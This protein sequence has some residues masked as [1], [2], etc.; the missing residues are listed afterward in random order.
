ML[1]LLPG[2]ARYAVAVAATAIPIALHAAL[3]PLWG[4]DLSLITFYA[5][6][7]V[8]AWL[9][10]MGPALLAT[11]LSAAAAYLWMPATGPPAGLFGKAAS[12]GLFIG[13]GVL[14]SIL[15]GALHRARARLTDNARALQN[16]TATS[17]EDAEALNRLAAIVRS[18]DD[19]I[20][21]KTLEG[22]I[23]TWNEAA[24]RMFGWTAEEAIGKS[25][26]LIIPHDRLREEEMVLSMIRRGEP[27][28]HFRTVRVHK[29]GK[30]L[31][32]SLTVSPVRNAAGEVVGASKI[33]RDV[34]AIAEADD[35]R[36]IL[37]MR[38]QAARTEAETANRTKDEF[39][40]MLG[41]ELRNP[42]SAISNAAQ[43]LERAGKPDDSTA[44]A[45]G[46]IVRQTANLARLMDGLLDV[47]RVMT[48]KILLDRKLVDLGEV[49]ERALAALREAGR[50]ER[51]LV[52]FDGTPVTIDA[53]ATRIEQ[54]VT[55]LVT[56][57]LKYTPQGGAVRIRVTQEGRAAVL[58]V[59]DD[60][61]GIAPALLP[62]VFDLFVQGP[63]PLDRSSG[64]L[65]IG[66][67][68]VKQVT[69]LHGGTVI[70]ASDGPGK[71]TTVTVSFPA[72]PARTQTAPADRARLLLRPAP[73]SHRGGQRRR[74]R[75][76]ADHARAPAPHGPGGGRRARGHRGRARVRARYRARRRRSSG[77]R[78]LRSRPLPPRGRRRETVA[79]DR[80]HRLRPAQGCGPRP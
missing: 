66:M 59:E 30:L 58:R 49:A 28:E 5:A 57:A 3:A 39:L 46:V 76:A 40:A 23:T 26:A 21:S 10:G 16:Q 14:I 56:N 8:S 18:S 63:P 17:P 7:M 6:V 73:G 60:G 1:P 31:Q 72:I 45:R 62:R 50:L 33:A 74:A 4:P 32:I 27:I 65:G 20:I 24:T 78:R 43:V 36:A 68:V 2:L 75:D 47:G 25:I 34:T 38:E 51:H 61:M 42:L 55:N 15:V 29:H 44:A 9:G 41:H 80:H 35:E 69:E 37:L 11:L 22:K 70:A 54:I 79:P 48:G 71:G 19:A 13:L 64:G 53:D 67:T 52:T 12:L 77:A